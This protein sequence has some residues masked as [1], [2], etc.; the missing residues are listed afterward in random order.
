MA[1]PMGAARGMIKIGLITQAISVMRARLTI[2]AI[3]IAVANVPVCFDFA[4]SREL[5]SVTVVDETT[6]PAAAETKTPRR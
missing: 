5:I 1:A 3:Q 6:A 2:Q 4:A